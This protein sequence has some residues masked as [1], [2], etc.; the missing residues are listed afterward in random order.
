M[1]GLQD[2]QSKKSNSIPG[3]GRRCAISPAR[4]ARLRGILPGVKRPG[5]EVHHLPSNSA[6]VKN[7][8]SYTTIFSHNLMACGGTLL[9]L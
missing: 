1:T 3:R 6:E 4:T 2:G 5:R 8:W 9:P 7:E